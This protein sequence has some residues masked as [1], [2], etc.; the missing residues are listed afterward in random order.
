MIEHGTTPLCELAED[1]SI[2]ELTRSISPASDLSVVLIG[3]PGAGTAL[4]TNPNH[5]TPGFESRDA[6]PSLTTALGA[7][8][9][10]KNHIQDQLASLHQELESMRLRP[11][12]ELIFSPSQESGNPT[13]STTPT[14]KTLGP[15][16]RSHNKPVLKHPPKRPV[17]LTSHFPKQPMRKFPSKIKQKKSAKPVNPKTNRKSILHKHTNKQCKNKIK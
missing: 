15:K 14:K 2:H 8:L 1:T 10:L 9:I 16:K 17:F 12:F 5:K 11:K 13:S 3:I 4:F 7:C 6:A